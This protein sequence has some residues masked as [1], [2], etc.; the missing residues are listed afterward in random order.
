MKLFKYP[1]QS[2]GTVYALLACSAIFFYGCKPGRSRNDYLHAYENK[3]G[4]KPSKL[5]QVDT[6][7]FTTIQWEEPVKNFGT[8]TE[9]DSVILVYKCRNT[10]DN[11]LFLSE[12]YTPCGCTVVRYTERVIPPGE[13][14]EITVHFN[15]RGQEKSVHKSIIVTSN[16]SNRAKHMLSFTGAITS[17]DTTTS[18]ATQ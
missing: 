11:P 14:D 7:H 18:K 5:A 13:E 8:V 1:F 15:T 16:T 10:G 2:A 3:L 9:G 6:I 12:I 17:A 4:I